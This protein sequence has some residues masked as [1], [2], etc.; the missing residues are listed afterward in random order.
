MSAIIV[1][2]IG[3]NHCGSV[4]TA[5]A[6]IG[7]AHAYGA[8]AV[9]FQ[10]RTVSVVYSPSDL[11][12]VKITQFGRTYGDE[13]YGLE[14]G[15]E[16]Y[17]QIDDYCRHVGIP[18]FASA[19]DLDSVEFLEQYDIPHIKVSSACLNNWPLIKR[20]A[21]G[22]FPVVLSTGMSHPQDIESAVRILG[23]K[24]K[25][26]LHATSEYPCPDDHMNMSRMATLRE[27]YGDVARIGF[28]SHSKK[29]IYPVA[30]V[31]MGA[32]MIEFHITLDRGMEGTDHSSSVGPTGF[33]RIM[34]HLK[35]IS[36]GA[37]SGIMAPFEEEI[38]KGTKY[39]W[40]SKPW[41]LGSIS[42]E[43]LLP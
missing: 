31:V 16:E 17:D 18:W 9:K 28:S 42:T 2:E 27:K 1:C 39:P 37:G 43:Q 7:M 4:D 6:L 13:K 11:A 20:V 3:I 38:K 8:S 30:A 19:W 24:L 14:F 15:K 36:I 35:S 29:V 5:K 12:K 22:K 26:L 32:E 41:L 34:K 25:Y 10:K 40:R 33:E 23:S 21:E